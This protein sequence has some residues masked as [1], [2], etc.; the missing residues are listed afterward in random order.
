VN[1]LTPNPRADLF[2][3]SGDRLAVTLHDA[4]Y[5]LVI[6]IQ[7]LT[8][9]RSGSMTASAA[10]GFGQVKFAPTGTSCTNIPYDFHSIYSTSSEKTRVPWT[11]H[12]YNVAFADE[13]GHFDF[14]SKVDT[15]AGSCIGQE[16][17]PTDHEKSDADD[18]F[19]FPAS[20]LV[21]VAGCIDTNVGFDGQSYQPVWPDGNT[22]LHPTSIA[23]SSPRTGTGF[24]P[25]LLP[26]GIRGQPAEDRVQRGHLQPSERR[27]MRTGPDH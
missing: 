20:T 23:F 22:Q 16:G 2:I 11:A 6:D 3:A 17:I 13:I 15:A 26:Y 8:S 24:K 21:R 18:N 27:R 14:C 7:D 25:A 9:G 4:G 19:C 10:N 1:T 12:A 5:G